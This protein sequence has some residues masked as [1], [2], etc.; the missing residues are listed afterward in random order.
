[1]QIEDYP[2]QEPQSENGLRY[3]REMLRRGE[4]VNGMEIRHGEDVHQGLLLYPAQRPN[5]TLLAFMCGG[6]WTNGYKELLAFMAPSFNAAGVTFA[7]LGYRLAPK[8][9]FPA[10]WLDAASGISWLYRHARD[11][12]VDPRRM[13]VGGH[14]AG[15]HYAALLGCRRDWQETLGLPP[16]VIRGCVCISAVFDFTPGNGMQIR[17]RFLGPEPLGNDLYASP[18]FQLRELPPPFL[19][20][21]GTED[22]PHLIVQ[23]KKMERVLRV[24]G[25]DVQR[26]ELPGQDHFSAA[27]TSVDDDS[28]WLPHALRWLSEHR[29]R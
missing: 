12:G 3:M 22:F 14:S 27:Y 10:G 8:H 26:V 13:F 11:Y 18:L 21:H 4:G 6:G 23:A 2:P 28:T 5:G 25:A 29:D 15:G 9:I 24:M 1:M 20:A 17:P 19:L 7:A 16:D